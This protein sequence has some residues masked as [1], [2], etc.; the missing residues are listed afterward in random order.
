MR[1]QQLQNEHFDWVKHNFPDATS[2]HQL[3]GV[4][5]EVGELSHAHLKSLQG[6]RG[7]T[8]EHFEAKCDAIADILIFLAGYANMEGIDIETCIDA[9]WAIVKERDW[10]KNKLDGS[11]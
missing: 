4:V 11:A 7:T 6:I 5:E 3:L 10:Q 1:I 2:W 8:D 9:S